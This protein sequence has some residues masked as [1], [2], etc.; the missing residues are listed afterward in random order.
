MSQPRY[1]I[2][3]RPGIADRAVQRVGVVPM[4]CPCCGHVGLARGFSE[5]LRETG[6]CGA[7]GATNRNRQVAVVACRAA[8]EL[9]GRRVC[10]LRALRATGLVVYNTE[11]QGALHDQLEA[12]PCYR[13]SEYLGPDH[14]PGEVVGATVH[15]DLTELSFD[16]GGIDL[17][18]SSDVLEH[19][20][21]PYRAHREVHRVLRPGGRHVFTVPFHQHAH[22]DDVRA[23]P[24]PAGEPELL[25]PPI[26]H[27]DPVRPEG[28]LVYTIFGLAMLVELAR[29][30]FD[31]RMYR[32]AEP[33]HGILGPNALVFE[34]V[35]V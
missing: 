6:R 29:I 1:P 28:V 8:S 25:A 10:D 19:V 13:C 24:G 22:L 21:D 5:N 35:K 7:C 18:L 12:M 15:E 33:W 20:P 31:T 4:R 26:Y 23:R 16:D 11:A 17:V 32:L 9:S 27:D 14:S 3:T 34:A 30:G 2:S